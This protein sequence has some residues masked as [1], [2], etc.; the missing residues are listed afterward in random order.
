MN[1]ENSQIS[2]CLAQAISARK[3]QGTTLPSNDTPIHYIWLHIT[4]KGITKKNSQQDTAPLALNDWLNLIDESAA[5]GA[6]WMILY[7][8]AHLT[9]NTDIWKICA[10]A[11]Q[12]H[13]IR[14]GLHIQAPFIP[15]WD[16]A[17]LKQLDQVLTFI[18]ADQ[19]TLPEL[20]HLHDQGYTLCHANITQDDRTLPCTHTHSIV[21]AA[22]DGV[23]FR[24][25][26][27]IG[28][29]AHQLGHIRTH[30]IQNATTQPDPQP[31]TAHAAPKNATCDG[32]PPIIVQ[33]YTQ[34]QKS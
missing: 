5:L 9:Q 34:Q 11:Q 16:F 26:L 27:V 23:M 21:C 15:D 17:A 4:P 7:F 14:V 19:T 22:A 32:C 28:N 8:E 20:T 6:K 30:T 2:D 13:N 29:Q 33:R 3:D 31:V 18:V 10:W 12:I 1:P 24:C 25:G